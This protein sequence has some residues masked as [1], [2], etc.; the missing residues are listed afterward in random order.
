MINLDRKNIVHDA[1]A[2]DYP[3]AVSLAKEWVT[4]GKLKD[5]QKLKIEDVYNMMMEEHKLVTN[6]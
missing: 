5:F 4:L 3:E 1:M 6:C 2:E